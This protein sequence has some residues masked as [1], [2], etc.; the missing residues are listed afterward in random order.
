MLRIINNRNVR[1]SSILTAAAL[2]TAAAHHAGA[3]IMQC[4]WVAGTT[5]QT[6][7]YGSWQLTDPGFLWDTY[8]RKCTNMKTGD[9]VW[10]TYILLR[11]CTAGGGIGVGVTPQ[12]PGGEITGNFSYTWVPHVTN[13]TMGPG[14][15]NWC[16]TQSK[17]VGFWSSNV[18]GKQIDK[19]EGVK[20]RSNDPQRIPVPADGVY[21]FNETRY[22]HEVMYNAWTDS[23]VTWD[24]ARVN[25]GESI[26]LAHV[27][28]G[29]HVYRVD[30]VDSLGLNFDAIVF[31]INVAP[32]YT[33]E[34]TSAF[35]DVIPMATVAFTND[36][37]DPI[38]IDVRAEP[39][40]EGLTMEIFNHQRQVGPGETVEFQ[41]EFYSEPGYAFIAG[42]RIE[43][44]IRV[45][46]LY[47]GGTVLAETLAVVY[48]P[49][50][51]DFNG[52]GAVD[53][54]D[55]ILVLEH[56]GR[57]LPDADDGDDNVDLDDLTAVL[58]N[59]NALC[60][61]LAPRPTLQP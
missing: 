32:S 47:P 2:A 12:G 9:A 38:D 45:F 31:N 40:L 5:M 60:A 52:D 16:S 8:E 10:C 4:E 7:T 37:P 22:T 27:E 29:P 61:Q 20:M 44:P 18:D 56:M 33:I 13:C 17:C 1:R 43:S 21:V 50:D 41:V 39:E 26:N 25:Y 14:V 53:N 51:G 42:A 36:S 54:L 59:F 15:A 30:P 57:P 34:Q 58:Q 23:V 24:G 28:P 55:L 3:A 49:C 11:Q 6:T 48:E 46:D 35:R 19:F